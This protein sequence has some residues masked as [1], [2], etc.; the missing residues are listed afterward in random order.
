[1]AGEH[2]SH[3]GEAEPER[4]SNRRSDCGQAD[5]DRGEAGLRQRSRS[6]DGPAIPRTR[7]SPKGL[8]GRE[9]VLTVTLFVSR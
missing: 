9:P 3:L 8:I 4:I 6:Q 5:P 1:V 7:Y 2:G